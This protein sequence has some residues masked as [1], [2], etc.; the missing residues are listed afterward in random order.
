MRP[1]P[2]RGHPKLWDRHLLAQL[3]ASIFNF[4]L[5]I[6]QKNKSVRKNMLLSKQMGCKFIM[7]SF[8][9]VQPWTRHQ[10]STTVRC[11][12]PH[13]LSL[14]NFPQCDIIYLGLDPRRGHHQQGRRSAIMNRAAGGRA[15]LGKLFAISVASIGSTNINCD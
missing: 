6:K 4:P 11:R 8:R 2:H 12:A 9:F 15:V 5:S 3:W 13:T 7:K 10:K 1:S 14:N